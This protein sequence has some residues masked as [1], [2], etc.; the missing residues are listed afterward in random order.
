VEAP[1]SD[2]GTSEQALTQQLRELE[3]H[4]IVQRKVYAKVPSKVEC[5]L[6]AF[7]ETVRPVMG[8]LND[9]GAKHINRIA[10][11]ERR[12]GDGFAVV[13]RRCPSG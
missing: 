5:S 13:Q 7:G 6:T 1:P 2:A 4:G 10:K 12:P 8:V 11:R 3:E 9:W